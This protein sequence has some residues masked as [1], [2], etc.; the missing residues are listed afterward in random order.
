MKK[1]PSKKDLKAG[2][3]VLEDLDI[4]SYWSIVQAVMDDVVAPFTQNL[5]PFTPHELSFARY[6]V[7]ATSVLG[8]YCWIWAYRKI[9]AYKFGDVKHLFDNSRSESVLYDPRKGIKY[10]ITPDPLVI[11]ALQQLVI[12]RTTIGM[13][14]SKALGPINSNAEL[15]PAY[16]QLQGKSNSTL[17]QFRM[18]IITAYLQGVAQLS[19]AESIPS[20]DQFLGVSSFWI[21]FIYDMDVRACLLGELDTGTIGYNQSDSEVIINLGQSLFD[22]SGPGE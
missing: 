16:R 9:C 18:A 15:G 6:A 8:G 21:R 5:I 1:R 20:L 13:N 14:N 2:I 12:Q 19:G 22:R 11:Y 17:L 3:A 7:L 4:N 10:K